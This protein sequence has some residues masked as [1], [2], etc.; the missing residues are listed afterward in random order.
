MITAE[1]LIKGGASRGG[2][3]ATLERPLDHLVACHRRI[4]QRLETL[5]RVVPH[6]A[7]RREEALAAIR[8]SLEFFDTN[9]A[10]HTEDEEQSVFP[11]LRDQVSPEQRAYL[12][13]LE[14]QHDDA[15]ALHVELTRRVE[16]MKAADPIP[17]DLIHRYA[18]VVGK[19][20]AI[21][22]P[23][24]ASEDA[25]LNE[26][27]RRVLGDAELLQIAGE[28]KRRRGLPESS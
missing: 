6:L 18:A 26:L 15:E 8:S 12:A 4:E 20:A 9:G 2:I 27:G 14:R 10:W 3:G 5:E 13:E 21:Y 16:D 24:I 23:H 1:Q 11:R 25:V 28:M 17:T 22:R 7:D 19:L